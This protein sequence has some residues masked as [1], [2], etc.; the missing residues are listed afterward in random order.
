MRRVRH[1]RL[2]KPQRGRGGGGLYHERDTSAVWQLEGPLS[3]SCYT[4]L[5]TPYHAPCPCQFVGGE[6]ECQHGEDECTANSWEQCAINV[7]PQFSTHWPFYLCV[8]TAAKV[9]RVM[10]PESCSSKAAPAPLLTRLGR[11]VAQACGEGAGPC[12]LPK[13]EGCATGAGLDYGLLSSCVGDKRRAS[14][15]QH[16]FGAC[17]APRTW[18]EP[19]GGWDRAP[20]S[21]VLPRVPCG[22]SRA[23]AEQPLLRAVGGRRGQAAQEHRCTGE[24]RVQQVQGREEAG[25]VRRGRGRGRDR[26]RRWFHLERS[27]VRG[28]VVSAAPTKPVR[29]TIARGG[30]GTQRA[31]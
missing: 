7:Y 1:V 5:S 11:R 16:E 8:E 22:H 31:R 4:P 3:G 23:D 18:F 30:G 2:H 13:I 19:R 26:G 27:R 6:L 28:R 21:S 10:A 20:V 9:R 14:R 29:V 12:V 15:L 25:G 24:A 17:L